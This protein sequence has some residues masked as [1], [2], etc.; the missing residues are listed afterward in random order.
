MHVHVEPLMKF[1][2]SGAVRFMQHISPPSRFIA[3]LRE[4]PTFSVKFCSKRLI[5]SVCRKVALLVFTALFTSIAASAQTSILTQHYDTSRTGQ[6]TAE[7]ILTT[8]NVNT[9]SF[10]KLFSISVQG[11][12]YA[13]PLYDPGVTI[14]GNGTHNV[15]Y[16]A[17]EH[18]SL[19]AFDADTGSQLWKVSFLING[20]TTLSTSNVG[21]T[22]DI[23]P[24]IGITGT[25]TIDPT[26]NTLYVVVN[27]KESGNLIYR[28]HAID[29]TTGAEKFNGPVLINASVPRTAPDGNGSIVP[30]NPQW[31]N[32]RPGLL[33]LNGYLYIGFSSHGDNGPWHGWVLGYSA[34]TLAQTGAWCTS[35]NGKG[36]GIWAAGSG[37]AADAAGNMYV[38]TGNGDDTVATLAPP[39][40][41]TIDYGDSLVR[42]SLTNGVPVPT[43]YFTPYNQA[44]L[45]SGDADVGSGGVLVLPD[46]PGPY[47]HILLQSGKQGS[48][49]VVNRDKMTSDGSHYCNGCSSDPEIIQTVSLGAGLWSMPAYWNSQIYVWGNGGHLEAYSLTNG[50]VSQSPTSTSGESS[51]FPG[52]TP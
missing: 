39:P 32:Q 36:N 42:L 19:Y 6:N 22:Q 9:T 28:L 4:S 21:G 3:S 24:E 47:T 15:L 5:R 50:T 27:T 44:S 41:T 52:S 29:I 7:S 43:D 51:N 2:A 23:N 18:D 14:P 45:D 12:V 34:S 16:V 17:T 10:G 37:L 40:S 13:Q 38:A 1:S 33:L 35:P 26:T 11:Y 49:Y 48:L 25:P 8:A 31:A 46:Q 30:L 20:A